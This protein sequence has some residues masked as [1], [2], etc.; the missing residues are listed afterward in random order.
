MDIEDRLF[1]RL[2]YCLKSLLCGFFSYMVIYIEIKILKQIFF[3]NKS[4]IL[5]VYYL[6]FFVVY[7]IGEYS[8]RIFY[9]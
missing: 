2:D 7:Y 6:Y 9:V 5:G 1:Q 8:N 4:C 3:K